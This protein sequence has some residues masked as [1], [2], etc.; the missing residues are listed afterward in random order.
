MTVVVLFLTGCASPTIPHVQPTGQ[1]STCGGRKLSILGVLRSTDHGATWT[2]LGNACMSESTIGAVDPTGLVFNGRVVLYVVDIESLGHPTPQIIYRTTSVDGVNFDQ[3]QP[4]YTQTRGMVDPFVLGMPGGFFR[5]YAPSD[6]EGIVS[7]VSSD[8]LVFMREDGVRTTVGGMP[9]ALLLPDNR[10]RLF[11][12]SGGITS[13]ISGDGLNFTEESGVRIPAP[14][15]TIV[16]NPQ[17]IHLADGSYLMLFSVHDIEHHGQPAPWDFTEIRLATST[18]GLD[19][20]VNPSVIGYGGTSC[21][22]EI[23][24]GTLYLYYVNRDP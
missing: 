10:V 24:D 21:V 12:S 3:P 5:L 19:W 22:V 6:G 8:G 7:A 18:D 9:G 11:L 4:S 14:T 13:M 15:N 16:D 23:P 1:A 17:P 20:T 2:S